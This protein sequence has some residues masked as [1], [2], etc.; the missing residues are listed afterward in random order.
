MITQNDHDSNSGP[1]VLLR[2]ASLRTMMMECS[3][4]EV[5]TQD[6]VMDAI[7]FIHS[8]PLAS[9]Q[10]WVLGSHPS[11]H[12]S[13]WIARQRLAASDSSPEPQHQAPPRPRNTT[14]TIT[15]RTRRITRLLQTRCIFVAH[16]SPSSE[17]RGLAVRY[18][19]T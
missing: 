6:I 16:L 2:E 10:S 18:G 1:P 5:S 8:D 3:A 14:T 9:N 15:S 4:I 19:P 7:T 13:H 17:Q 11:A 12:Q